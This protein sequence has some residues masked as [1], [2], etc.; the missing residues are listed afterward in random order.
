METIALVAAFALVAVGAFWLSHHIHSV[1]NS[2]ASAVTAALTLHTG[3]AVINTT[4]ADLGA[5]IAAGLNA[6]AGPPVVA[7]PVVAAP[8]VAAPTVTTPKAA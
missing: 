5:A 1:A 7:A 4:A 8:V 2:A 3:S 6:V